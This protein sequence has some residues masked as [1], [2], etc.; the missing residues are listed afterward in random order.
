[1]ICQ[2]RREVTSKLGWPRHRADVL[3]RFYCQLHGGR[4]FVVVAG[5]KTG[6][7][8]HRIGL[9]IKARPGVV[10]FSNV[11]RIQTGTL[12]SGT[13]SFTV[14]PGGHLTHLALDLGG[15]MEV[16]TS[17][18][19]FIRI[20]VS[21][22]LLRYGDRTYRFPNDPG[23]SVTAGGVIGNSLLVTAGFSYRLGRL[24]THSISNASTR[25]WEVGSQYGVLSLGRSEL[26]GVPLTLG[27]DQ[28]IGGRLTYNFNRWL[29]LDSVVNYF[30]TTSNAADAQRGGKILQGSFGPKAGIRTR[31]FGVFAKIRPGFLSY[32]SVHDDFSPPFPTTRL[33][34][35]AVDFGGVLEYYPSR[36]TMLRFDLGQTEVFYGSANVVAP[37]G[38]PFY[39]GFV[40]PAFRDNGLQ[41]TTGFGWRF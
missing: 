17:R 14:F 33:T 27:D 3:P 29:A 21:E 19:T 20:D 26:R 38:P 22:M 12:P 28:G 6:W 37:P 9:F 8:W 30:Y 36:R 15:T 11:L 10:N 40:N 16:S 41:F 13:P 32:G 1:M 5:P 39:G 35:F 4:A 34:H 23:A 2:R 18:R 31:R 24:D 7:R 25:R